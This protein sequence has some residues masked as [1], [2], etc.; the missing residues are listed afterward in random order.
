MYMQKTLRRTAL[1]LI[2]TVAILCMGIFAAACNK[3]DEEAT[4]FK[5]TVVYPD[6]KAVNGETDGTAGVKSDGSQGTEVLIQLCDADNQANCYKQ[7]TLGTDGTLEIKISDVEKA[8][9]N[10]KNYELHINGL[11]TGYSYDG[12]DTLSKD[13]AEIKITLKA[14]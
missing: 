3:D 12:H 6:G 14:N 11:P 2:I 9:K 1:G 4:S 13:N 8:L 7:L 10:A 5:I